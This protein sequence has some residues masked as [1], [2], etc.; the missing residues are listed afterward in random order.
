MSL[1]TLSV[2]DLVVLLL[3]VGAVIGRLRR[4]GGPLAAIGSGLATLVV[5]WLVAVG[6]ATWA[7]PQAADL[8]TSSQLL[9]TVAVPHHA[10]DQVERLL[11]VPLTE[12]TI[13]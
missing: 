10:I 2:V 1:T 4:G 5:A 11:G 3:V 12:R 6:V 9:N 7:P 8:A 13:R